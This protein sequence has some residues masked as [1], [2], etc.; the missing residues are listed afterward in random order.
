[1]KK[2]LPAAKRH[3]IITAIIAVALGAGGY[4]MI[5]GTGNKEEAQ[6]S[7]IYGIATIATVMQS[8]SGTGQIEASKQTDVSAE[9]AGE[10]VRVA[11]AAGQEVKAGDVI[12]VIDDS[13]GR[14]LVE[15]AEIALYNVQVSLNDLLEPIDALDLAKAEN[16]VTQAKKTLE[17]DKTDLERSYEQ[18]LSSVASAFNDLPTMIAGLQEIVTTASDYVVQTSPSYLEYYYNS[19][20]GYD[21]SSAGLITK[22]A[23]SYQE[24]KKKYDANFENYKAASRFSSEA[25]IEAL[26]DETYETTRAV[27][28]ALKNVANVIQNYEDNLKDRNMNPQG[29]AD[30]QLSSLS[31]HMSTNSS[32]LS[33]LLSVS[34]AIDDAKDAIDTDTLSLE[35]YQ[36]E[37]EELQEGTD[38]DDIQSARY[39]VQQ[40]E[41]ALADA[42]KTLEKYTII[43]PFDGVVATV[44]A[45]AGDDVTSGTP[46][47]TVI[48]KNQIVTVSLNEVDIAKVKVGQ[49]ATLTFDA[50][51]ELTMTGTVAEVATIGTVDS[52]VV[53]YDVTIALDSAN[54]QVKPGMSASVTV[55]TDIAQD[56]LTVPSAAVKRA[57]DG[58]YYVLVPAAVAEGAADGTAAQ[59]IKQT[60]TVGLDDDTSI[61]IA[62][63]LNEGDQVV[64][65]S[66]KSSAAA[67]KSSGSS[68]SEGGG[69][70][71]MGGGPR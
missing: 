67:A 41:R 68:T 60:V 21:L 50:I 38:E 63:G 14:D 7:Y 4:Y 5:F 28:D 44:D 65:T 6:T 16:A 3:K 51:D 71:M 20:K 9:V 31:A 17:S 70:M 23:S 45:E 66:V 11:V 56:V 48:T 42:K 24:A 1:M 27:A 34:Q 46:M 55:I 22:A 33:N 69:F 57:E 13:D 8:V 58:L 29:F 12:A 2:L 54:S 25:D 18:G 19:V 62:S 35:E 47:A 39:A 40:K 49:Q 37:L 52:G 26:I 36:Q 30:T 43:A 10:L 53:Y 61:E 64:V 15:D 59:A 32:N